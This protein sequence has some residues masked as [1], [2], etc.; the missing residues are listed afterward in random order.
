MSFLTKENIYPC[1][2][3]VFVWPSVVSEMVT[4][5]TELQPVNSTR[6]TVY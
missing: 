2:V 4:N 5:L 1:E 6:T 3:E